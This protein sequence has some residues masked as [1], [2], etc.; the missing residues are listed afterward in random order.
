MRH[1]QAFHG[2]RK[3]W[4]HAQEEYGADG[5]TGTVNLFTSASCPERLLSTGAL[6]AIE[7][8]LLAQPRPSSSTTESTTRP[9]SL[10]GMKSLRQTEVSPSVPASRG[11]HSLTGQ[12]LSTMLSSV[13][14]FVHHQPS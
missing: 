9:G 8:R 5:G 14:H 13:K 6:L 3:T 10:R 12:V 7:C 2:C 1:Y 11:T 4:C